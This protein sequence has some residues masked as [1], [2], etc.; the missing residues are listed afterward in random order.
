MEILQNL[1]KK[2]RKLINKQTVEYLRSRGITK[3]SAIKWQIGYLNSESTILELEGDHLPLYQTGLLIKKIDKS[4]L[5]RYITFPMYDQYNNIIGFS[6]RPPL[7][8][9]VVKQRGLKKYWHSR[10]NKRKFLFG[11]NHAIQTAREKN[12]FIVGEGQFDTIIAHQNNITN[13]VSTC[14]TALTED[15]VI[16][17]SRYA[18]KAFVVFD[19]DEAGVKAKSQLEK[20]QDSEIKLIPVTLPDTD[21]EKQDPD[22]YIRKF[23]AQSFLDRLTEAEVDF[24]REQN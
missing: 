4:P 2:T 6:G 9:Q 11:L 24:D 15:Q 3:Q 1:L 8:N 20:Y 22:S 14:G 10:F 23:G 18:E 19:N 17:L 16:M 21:G 5:T 12:Y 13:M 7:S